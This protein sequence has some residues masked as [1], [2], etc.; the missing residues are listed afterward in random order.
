MVS[1]RRDKTIGHI[2][3][4]PRIIYQPDAKETL[5]IG[6]VVYLDCDGVFKPALA[7]PEKSDVAGV[8]W[9]FE[10]VHHFYLHQGDGP[11]LYRF[12]LTPDY[13]SKDSDGRV[14]EN[15]PDITLIPGNLGDPLYL[16]PDNPG[17]LTHVKPTGINECEVQVGIKMAYGFLY[18]PSTPNCCNNKID[19]FCNGDPVGVMGMGYTANIT[20][21]CS[22]CPTITFQSPECRIIEEF[23][24]TS[25]FP[26]VNA[27]PTNGC[28][29]LTIT[30]IDDNTFTVSGMATRVS[31]M[32]YAVLDSGEYLTAALVCN[33]ECICE[34]GPPGPKGD[35][36]VPGEIGPEGPPGE[37]GP[38]GPPG[39]QGDPGPKGPAGP[40]GPAGIDGNDGNDGVCLECVETLE[41]GC[42]LS[43]EET[44]TGGLLTNTGI[45]GVSPGCLPGQ[46]QVIPGLCDGSNPIL[47]SGFQGFIKN[48]R[49]VT[50][51]E[52]CKN[53]E[54]DYGYMRIQGGE[55]N[56]PEEGDCGGG[57]VPIANIT[58]DLVNSDCTGTIVTLSRIQ[59]VGVNRPDPIEGCVNGNIRAQVKGNIGIDVGGG[60]GQPIELS[61]DPSCA[62]IEFTPPEM[63]NEDGNPFCAIPGEAIVTGVRYDLVTCNYIATYRKMPDIVV[64]EGTEC[65]IDFIKG[66]SFN[67][68]ECAWE[69][70]KGT[71]PTLETESPESCLSPGSDV[72]IGGYLDN[73]ECQ[74]KLET[75]TT[76][77]F[78][79]VTSTG[80]CSVLTGV[81]YSSE[82]CAVQF[83]KQE[84]VLKVEPY[85][86]GD[87]GC[88]IVSLDEF[89]CEDGEI[90]LRY[91]KGNPC[92]VYS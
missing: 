27:D 39:E 78:E 72:V 73:E 41:Y 92:C 49:T 8:I 89:V 33:P 36:G 17:R 47:G 3:T 82:D 54:Y 91:T 11:M 62:Y 7:V 20:V 38:E 22:A 87:E 18:Q 86:S 10:D 81:N 90:V 74:Y 61:A 83:D 57:C 2:H 58:N 16:S 80:S 55:C 65:S 60:A 45:V 26:L 63:A 53:L 79:E 5:E 88:A 71:I 4:D 64:G 84:L 14:R 25:S 75:A 24:C 52:G 34:P 69:L 35:P 42:G 51:E 46:C 67:N 68:E 21:D 23:D 9:S 66:V 70:D 77:V 13:F 6:M 50:L 12:P 15:A 1:R 31:Y 76:P 32:L 40:P 43:L 28:S 85:S 37:I 19:A 59:G 29:D 56:N 48:L 44:E 30:R